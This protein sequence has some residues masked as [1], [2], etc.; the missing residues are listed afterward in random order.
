MTK[1]EEEGEQE[2][3]KVKIFTMDLL[4]KSLK[5]TNTSEICTAF[6]LRMYTIALTCVYILLFMT[7]ITI[8]KRYRNGRFECPCAPDFN[9]QFYRCFLF[10]RAYVLF[11]RQ[12]MRH[13][14]YESTCLFV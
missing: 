13:I 6:L 3:N 2:S 4:I 8:F 12:L 5:T 7:L 9:H 14:K 11:F 1:K 10:F